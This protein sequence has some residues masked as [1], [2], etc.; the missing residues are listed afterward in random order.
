MKGCLEIAKYC[1]W[2]LRFRENETD[3]RNNSIIT[4]SEI[5]NK[6][7]PR[8]VTKQL[9]NAIKFGSVEA[10]QR[11]PRLLQIV[12]FYPQDESVLKTFI[13]QS[14][15]IPCWMF[16]GWLSQM[17]AILDKYEAKAVYSIIENIANYYPQVT[18]IFDNFD[19]EQLKIKKRLYQGLGLSV[20]DKLRKFQ[21]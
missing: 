17:T 2:F 3:E 11:F 5:V 6:E 10:R 19:F 9:L 14:Q 8:V 16:L 1:D 18:L 7:F 12:S 15:T 20:Q 21:V 4:R 13:D